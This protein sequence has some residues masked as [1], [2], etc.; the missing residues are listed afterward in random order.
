MLT[1]AVFSLATD[2]KWKNRPVGCRVAVREDKEAAIALIILITA[3]RVLYYQL[4]MT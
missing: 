3:V 1:S 4:T 2:L